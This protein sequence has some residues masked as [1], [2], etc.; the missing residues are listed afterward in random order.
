MSFFHFTP[1]RKQW[2]ASVLFAAIG[3]TSSLFL[4]TSNISTFLRKPDPTATTLAILISLASLYLF[5]IV[6]I[7]RAR[8]IGVNPKFL[9]SALLIIP[10]PF[11]VFALGA[12]PSSSQE[13]PNPF[14]KHIKKLKLIGKISTIA[15]SFLF[16]IY[17]L[18]V[19]DSNLLGEFMYYVLYGRDKHLVSKSD[20]FKDHK[21]LFSKTARNLIESGKCTESD[22]IYSGGW[23]SSATKGDGRYFIWCDDLSVRYDLNVH[24]QRIDTHIAPRKAK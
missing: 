10:A 24:T 1:G 6:S 4:Y 22:F 12:L 15:I 14:Q 23:I 7:N 13:T 16:F 2:W 5:T 8:A 18:L 3:L 20:D 21:S 19:R 9:L 17:L 11:W